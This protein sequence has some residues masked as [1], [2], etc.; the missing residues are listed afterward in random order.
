M[1]SFIKAAADPQILPGKI[2]KDY[3]MINN[4]KDKQA[5]DQLILAEINVLRV[6]I[7]KAYPKDFVVMQYH[8]LPKLEQ[9]LTLPPDSLDNTFVVKQHGKKILNVLMN[10]T[11][12]ISLYP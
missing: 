3:F 2:A 6:R 4:G 7:G 10:E 8:D 5:K 12:I 11:K 1:N 9:V